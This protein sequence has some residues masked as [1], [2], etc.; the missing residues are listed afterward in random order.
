[1]DG[2]NN[3]TDK[4]RCEREIDLMTNK[5]RHLNIVRGLHIKPDTFLIELLKS[6]S[7]TNGILITEYCEGGDLRRQ[8]NDTQNASGMPETEVRNILQALKNIVFYLHSM[9][10]IV[11][12]IKPENIAIHRTNDG[13]MIYKVIWISI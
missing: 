9:S 6:H 5:I 3:R 13:R 1:M 2:A 8:L 12:D 11:R 4:E 7:L 10:I